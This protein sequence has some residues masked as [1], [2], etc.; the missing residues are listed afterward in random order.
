MIKKHV[1]AEAGIPPSEAAAILTRGAYSQYVSTAKWR[2]RRWRF[3]QHSHKNYSGT[4][5]SNK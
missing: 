4:D 1:L 2:E 5:V 3:F